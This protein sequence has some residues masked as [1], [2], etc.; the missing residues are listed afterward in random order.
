MQKSLLLATASILSLLIL[1]PA[2]QAQSLITTAQ[3]EDCAIVADWIT[4]LEDVP[5]PPPGVKYLL[6][7]LKSS[8]AN[9]CVHLN[10][11]QVLGAHNSYHL[12]PRVELYDFLHSITPAVEAWEYS[13]LQLPEQ[14]GGQGIRQ[15]EL[16][17]YGDPNGGRFF[18]RLGPLFVGQNPFGPATLLFPGMKVL[19]IP[20]LDFETTCTRLIDC[21][22]ELKDWSDANPL[23]LPVMVLV[24]VKTDLL[25]T[26]PAVAELGLETP[27]APRVF[28]PTEFD[29]LDAEIRSVFPEDELFTP[30]DLR[31]SYPTLEQAVL[32]EGWPTLGALRGQVFFAMDNAGEDRLNYLDGHP[33]L[34]G[35][36]MFTNS[37][38]GQPDA[39]FVKV[40]DPLA[41]PAQIPDL[42]GT[43]YLVRTRADTDT[44]EA[45]NGD[46]Q[47]RDA[48]LASG[49][50]F[51]S[52]DFPVPSTKPGFTDYFVEIPNG[53]PARCNPVTGPSGCRNDALE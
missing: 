13:H 4:I 31:G 14:L 2:T 28:S 25:G 42:V 40:N 53:S 29:A 23:H 3:V 8:Y 27:D 11:I 50:Q 18:F 9:E 15:L 17:V 16:D 21:L 22:R 20:H 6:A 51:V 10:E 46:T 35:R 39:A 48:A 44:E 49:A 38:P 34:E 32:S 24:E 33:S 52:T 45:R 47:R 30:D 19:H 5:D 7:L 36:V 26:Q 43:G 37:T 1:T 12:E 41:N